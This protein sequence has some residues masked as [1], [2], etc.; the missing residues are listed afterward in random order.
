L[1]TLLIIFLILTGSKLY[2]LCD[3]NFPVSYQL[4]NVIE[5]GKLHSGGDKGKSSRVF[6][7]K[8]S[9]AGE[10]EIISVW[11]GLEKRNIK[12]TTLN[13]VKIYSS[14]TQNNF[15]FFILDENRKFY[16]SVVDTNANV[17]SMTEIINFER[18]PI[19]SIQ[20]EKIKNSNDFL[21]LIN[22]NLYLI[23]FGNGQLELNFISSNVK[24]ATGFSGKG[25]FQF[26]FVSSIGTWTEIYFVGWDRKEKMSERIQLSSEIIIYPVEDHLAIISTNKLSNSSWLHFIDANKGIV[27]KSLV[28]ANGQLID[29]FK[30]KNENFLSLLS[31]DAG[32]YYFR[33]FRIENDGVRESKN[34]ELPTEMIE[35]KKIYFNEG[36]IYSIFR[37]GIMT[38][39]M[40][41]GL[42]SLDVYPLGEYFD[43]SPDI[44]MLE[45]HLILSSLS[46]TLIFD[47]KDNQFWW[48]N[49]FLQNTGKIVLPAIL[50]LLLVLIYRK[51][52][53]QK[54]L[55]SAI[56]DLPSS[57][58]VFVLDKRSRL[59]SANDSGKQMLKITDNIPMRRLFQ[60]YCDLE[61]T[62]G[63]KELVDKAMSLREPF[64]QKI[65]IF[66]NSSIKEWYFS[67]VLLTGLTGKFKGCV[68]TGYD[69]T[70]QLERKRL[71]NW[72]QLAHDMQ[73]NLST[74]RLNA[75]QLECAEN[76]V[77]SGRRQKILHQA[78]L[79]IHR[80][81]DIVTVGRSS[82]P[83]LQN[84]NASEVCLE[85]RSEFDE[86]MFPNVKFVLDLK[87]FNIIC[88]KPKMIR[89]MRNLIENGIRSLKERDGIITLSNWKDS[90]YC[91]FVVK[92]NGVGMDE[93]QQK[94][95]LTPY[96]S[97]SQKEGGAGIGTMIIQNVVE[98]HGGSLKV[99]SE[100]GKGTEVVISL[101]L[102]NK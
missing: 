85:A 69:I 21:L 99:N 63:L 77:N 91:Y 18:S 43:D 14:Y 50:F 56:I 24:A 9:W 16:L 33:L 67:S 53:R 11:D 15:L 52:R 45:N 70:E 80:I 95:M 68:L 2:L 78:G 101:P 29:V 65:D 98:Q 28:N 82:D 92:D 49:R 44:F 74:I 26:A 34:F 62:K 30:Y 88:D 4:K 83:E 19:Y 25:K 76:E 100:L 81:R 86:T 57:G 55:L 94:N 35:A 75:E 13:D 47:R 10:A 102:V 39:S 12:S 38:F 93:I 96:F 64:T 42:L 90:K 51:Y 97:T 17:I 61:R 72:A 1:K 41:D 46:T 87:D 58:V 27:G 73:T 71:T 7:I 60:Y 20:W 22:D 84:V 40:S 31:Y 37:N 66:E 6:Y 54:R 23:D 5:G 79:L 8:P 32:S 3:E 89:A 59:R 48:V 36:I